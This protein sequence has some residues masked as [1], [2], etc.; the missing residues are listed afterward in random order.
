MFRLGITEGPT[1]Q[2]FSHPFLSLAGPYPTDVGP[3]PQLATIL[4]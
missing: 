4:M 3:R 2:D 1:R